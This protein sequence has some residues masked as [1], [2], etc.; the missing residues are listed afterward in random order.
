[1]DLESLG[2][3]VKLRLQKAASFDEVEQVR[4]KY[5]GKKGELTK[6]LQSI[7][8]L[9]ADE[10]PEAG[11]GAQHQVPVRQLQGLHGFHQLHLSLAE[12]PTF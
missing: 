11:R 9:P 5:L 8:K 6:V 7:G 4:I 3:E 2:K 10:R 1:M 12:R